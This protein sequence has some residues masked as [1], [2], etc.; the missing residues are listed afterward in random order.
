MAEGERVDSS[1]G[2]AAGTAS[3]PRHTLTILR[4]WVGMTWLRGGWNKLNAVDGW[5]S[6]LLRSIER[7]DPHRH[8]EAFLN[9]VVVP[10]AAL[11]STLVSWGEFSVGVSLLLGAGTRLGAGVGMFLSL[12][13]ML[14]QSRFFPGYD[15]T[16]FV[17]QMV[18][19]IG[20]AGRAG[21][22]DAYLHRRWP[23]AQIW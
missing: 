1:D 10:H 15:G 13:Y 4:V 3:M 22:V 23:S 9:G 8:Y 19:F 20:A 12:N 14:L 6:T 18:L 17:A 16:L 5:T 21:G 11:F 2:K 7:S